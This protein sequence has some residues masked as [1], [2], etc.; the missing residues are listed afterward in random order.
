M[1]TTRQLVELFRAIAA[2]DM[3]AAS[4]IAAQVSKSEEKNGHRAAARLLRG[5][6]NGSSK[7]SSP[8]GRIHSATHPVETA[9]VLVFCGG[10]PHRMAEG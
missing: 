7:A 1:A 3:D 5:A 6:L 2:E 10:S 9:G 8:N 4:A